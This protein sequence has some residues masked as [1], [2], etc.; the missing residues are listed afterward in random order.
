MI[1]LATPAADRFFLV[2]PGAELAEGELLLES[3]SG[4][5]RRVDPAAVSAF[6]V[7]RQEAQEHVRAEIEGTLAGVAGTL[8]NAFGVAGDEPPDLRR[9]AERLGLSGDDVRAAEAAIRGVAADAQALVA[10]LA[11]GVDLAGLG[12]SVDELVER[13]ERE[14]GPYLGR[15][16]E[17]VR[18][19]RRAGYER[20]ARASI[21]ESLREAGITPLN[22]PDEPA[23]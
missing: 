2:P 19:Q 11:S 10:E 7:S 23:G 3:A 17:R 18:Q 21:A 14:V 16:P 9:P 6:E 13:L 20:D 4:E 15:D 5:E 22:A 8:A 12:R 1:L